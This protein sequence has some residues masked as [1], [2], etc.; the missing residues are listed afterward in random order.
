MEIDCAPYVLNRGSYARSPC[1]ARLRVLLSPAPPS[2]TQPAIVSPVASSQLRLRLASS[3]RRHRQQPADRQTAVQ[4]LPL[5]NAVQ[6]L[7]QLLPPPSTANGEYN[8]ERQMLD[9]M[10]HPR[11]R[12]WSTKLKGCCISFSGEYFEALSLF[13]RLQRAG[14]R[15]GRHSLPALLKS[16]TALS[17]MELGKTL[18]GHVVKGG[19][20]LDVPVRKA[21]INM[22]AKR[23][24]LYDSHRLFDHHH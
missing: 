11:S 12:S 21:L 7:L 14:L 24:F 5:A 6:L 18:H 23:G 10:A 8:V 16:C 22:Y 17:E 20:D 15:P 2:P 9:E 3:R 1:P 4:L 13:A 19:Y